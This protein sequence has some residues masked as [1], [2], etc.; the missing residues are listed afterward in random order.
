[1]ISRLRKLFQGL[2]WK[3]TLSYTLVTVGAL[4]VVAVIAVILLWWI[5]TSAHIYPRAL[6]TVL[7]EE[8][9]PQI[10]VFIDDPEPDL[11]GLT[12][13]LKAAE[14][15]AGLTFQSLSIPV[16][17]VTIS[18]VD[19][20]VNLLV[21]DE[22]LNFLAGLPLSI[23]QE[24]QPI[25]DQAA[26]AIEAAQAGTRDPL[27]LTHLV[28]GESL[29]VVAPVLSD[30]EQHLGFLLLKTAYPPRGILTGL[31][32][33]IGGSL[34]FFTIAAGLVG[35]VF[36]FITARGLTRRIN[37]V[38][39]ATD[40]W[41]QGNFSTFIQV[42]SPDVLG[43]LA[44]RLNRMA[45]K[46]Q[47]LMQTHQELAVLEERNRLARD[48]HDGVKQQVFATAMQLGTARALVEEDITAA[49]KHLDEAENLAKKT[50]ADLTNI[51]RELQPEPLEKRGLVNALR[52]LV[53]D[54]SRMNKIAVSCSIPDKSSLPKKVEQVLF[55]VAQ[56]AFSNIARHSQATEVEINFTYS[57]EEASLTIV[58]NGIGFDQSIVE[59]HNLGL[60]SMYERLEAVGGMFQ[61]DSSPGQGTRLTV[62][63]LI[64]QGESL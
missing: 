52:E 37:K 31:I 49:K 3:L 5:I 53:D 35:T 59:D 58:D 57:G 8:I 17:N 30:S 36:G 43:Q 26:H 61:V 7:R 25:L 47:N 54:W 40:L 28:P 39:K 23:Q 44:L 62:R 18:D 63:C 14:S 51:I 16:F 20:N 11:E 38:S 21:L 55:R 4:L 15:S 64:H 60:R 48:L 46:L 19:E 50:Q 41:A 33:Y 22:Q 12:G 34:I 10:A 42:S 32:S 2:Q 27:Q 56:E 6:I 24:Y 9:G 13:W 45:E 29:S 1:M